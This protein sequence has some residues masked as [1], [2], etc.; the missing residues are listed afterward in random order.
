MEEIRVSE[1]LALSAVK[2]N[3]SY[4]EQVNFDND[5]YYDRINT[6]HMLLLHNKKYFYANNF[7]GM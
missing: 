2:S 3:T 5:N 1:F 4:I 6:L 7:I